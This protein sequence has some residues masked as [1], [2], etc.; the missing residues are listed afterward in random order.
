M[1]SQELPNPADIAAVR[2]WLAEHTPDV[3]AVRAWAARVLARVESVSPCP[4]WARPS[5]P[6]SPTP[7]RGS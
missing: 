6:R 2:R 4:S 3:G 5:G 7:T 1:T